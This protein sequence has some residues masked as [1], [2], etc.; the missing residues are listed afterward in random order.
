ML[1][2]STLYE[3]KKHLGLLTKDAD[4][5]LIQDWINRSTGLIEWWKDR[6]YYPHKE[7]QMLDCPV[8]NADRFGSYG[9]NFPGFDPV[10]IAFNSEEL[11]LKV[12]DLLEVFELLNGDGAEIEAADYL[13]EPATVFPKARILLKKTPGLLWR[14]SNLDY[15]QV[16][17]LEAM[18]GFV[19]NYLTCFVNSASLIENAGGI[20]DTA[21]TIS[22]LDFD[23]L[24]DDLVSPK[25]Q[26][27]QM[28]KA[29]D[30]FMFLKSATAGDYEDGELEV[31]RGFV[32]TTKAA[33]AEDTPIYIYRIPMEVQQMCLRLVQWR[34]RQKDNDNFDRIFNLATQSVSTPSALP[35]D[36]AVI[37]G[38][39]GRFRL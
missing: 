25:F 16:I 23:G 28:L 31:V 6:K 38:R 29:E 8:R 20:N 3:M 13:L 7:T 26:A 12:E 10:N 33:H 4:D 27:G 30:E 34:Y 24:T 32:G 35:A 36:V 17:S 1:P 39:R 22:V 18:W 21:T 14:P 9:T 15:K 5:S 2:Y 19:E 11:F 37:L